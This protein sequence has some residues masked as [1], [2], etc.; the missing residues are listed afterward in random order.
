MRSHRQPKP[1]TS[2]QK[3]G[4]SASGLIG[5]LEVIES[6]MGT[7]LSKTET[8]ES[9]AQSEYETVTQQNK[10]LKASKEKDAEYKTKEYKGL[11][12]QISEMGSDYSNVGQELTAVT[13][14]LIKVKDRC[15]AKPVTYE[16]RKKR[17]EA[18]MAGLKEA[19]T[20]FPGASAGDEAA[21][22]SFL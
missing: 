3:S 11:E 8:E 19:L 15:V 1:P 16:Q 9:E 7:S 21:G 20:Y 17:R 14:S 4:G 5:M 12:K 2:H 18:E 6:D 13:E 22:S 10:V